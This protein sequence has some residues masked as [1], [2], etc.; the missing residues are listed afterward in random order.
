MTRGLLAVALG[1][2]AAAAAVVAWNRRWPARDSRNDGLAHARAGEVRRRIG[3]ARERLQRGGEPAGD[4]T[5]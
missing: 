3:H 5:R 4:H 2:D 1:A